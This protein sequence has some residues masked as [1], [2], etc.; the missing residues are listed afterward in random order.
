MGIILWRIGNGFKS[1]DK[2]V[3]VHYGL[4]YEYWLL[5]LKDIANGILG[6]IILTENLWKYS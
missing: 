1:S 4:V 3:A 6:N 5:V 2:T